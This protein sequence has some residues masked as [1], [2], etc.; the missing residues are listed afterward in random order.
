MMILYYTAYHQ[1]YYDIKSG[2]DL[3]MPLII[4]MHME[5]VD[6][7][8]VICVAL[9]TV[10]IIISLMWSGSPF[11]TILRDNTILKDVSNNISLE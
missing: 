8:L 11:P 7:V 9:L 6:N 5:C 4:G 2:K 1:L 3:R 10:A